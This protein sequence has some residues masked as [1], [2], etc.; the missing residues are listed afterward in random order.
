MLLSPVGVITMSV[1]FKPLSSP[2]K[3]TLP[4][5]SAASAQAVNNATAAIVK[6]VF[7][8]CGDMKL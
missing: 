7:F 3:L 1:S 5:V 8:I 4:L 2:E 6:I